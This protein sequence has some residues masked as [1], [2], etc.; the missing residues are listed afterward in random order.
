MR[1]AEGRRPPLLLLAL[2]V[3]SCVA[4]A[5]GAPRGGPP[6]AEREATGYQPTEHI[7]LPSG[8]FVVIHSEGPC[9]CAISHLVLSK[10][11]VEVALHSDESYAALLR[12]ADAGAGEAPPPLE[13]AEGGENYRRLAPCAGCPEGRRV[14]LVVRNIAHIDNVV[15]V[16]A[17]VH[18]S[19]GGSWVIPPL[20]GAAVRFPGPCPCRAAYSF[21]VADGGAVAAL[22]VPDELLERV[23]YPVSSPLE[24]AEG[25]PY[26]SSHSLPDPSGQANGSVPF[27]RVG[28]DADGGRAALVLFN[29]TER[30]INASLSL[31]VAAV[32]DQ[33]RV[34]SVSHTPTE[35]GS[36]LVVGSG[37]GPEGR[38]GVDEDE[39]SLR[40]TVGGAR[41]RR[42]LV[43]FPDYWLECWLPPGAGAGLPLTVSLGALTSAPAPFT[44]S[45]PTVES[46]DPIPAGGGPV[47]VRGANLGPAGTP[48]RLYVGPAECAAARVAEPH[49]A[50]ACEAPP[51]AGA[52][53]PVYVNVSGLLTRTGHAPSASYFPPPAPP[54][55]PPPGEPAPWRIVLAGPGEEGGEGSG[56]GSDGWRTL[57]VD[58]ASFPAAV[59]A[60]ADPSAPSFPR[61]GLALPA[62]G[63]LRSRGARRALPSLR[64]LCAPAARP[65]LRRRRRRPRRPL[66][67]RLSAPASFDPAA[68][69]PLELRYARRP[70]LRVP[71][72]LLGPAPALCLLRASSPY[73]PEDGPPLALTPEPLSPFPAPSAVLRPLL[74]A[75]FP[76]PP[77][78]PS[79]P[80]PPP[81][82]PS[83]PSSSAAP[84]GRR[85]PTPASASTRAPPPP[86]PRP[87]PPLAALLS[88]AASARALGRRRRPAFRLWLRDAAALGYGPPPPGRPAPARALQPGRH[89]AHLRAP[90]LARVQAPG[91][92]PALLPHVPHLL[93]PAGP[94]SFPPL[95]RPPVPSSGAPPDAPP[96]RDR[97]PD[98]T[99]PE[100]PTGRAHPEAPP[101]AA[102]MA[103]AP[104]PAVPPPYLSFV[105]ASRNDDYGGGLADRLQLVVRTLLIFAARWRLS[106]EIVFVEWNPPPD[107]PALPHALV[108]P[109]GGAPGG[110]PPVP[111]RHILV[112]PETHRRIPNSERIPMFDR[113]A[114][115]VGVRR[116]RGEFILFMNQDVLFC[117]GL[118]AILA[119]RLLRPGAFY[120]ARRYDVQAR[121]PPFAPYGRALASLAA[122][123][124]AGLV[125]PSRLAAASYGEDAAAAAAGRRAPDLAGTP[126]ARLTDSL[127]DNPG[128][129]HIMHRTHWHRARANPESPTYRHVD[130]WFTALCIAHNLSYVP[131]RA[132]YGI[133]HIYHERPLG[134][135]PELEDE[136]WDHFLA[137]ARPA[138][139][140]LFGGSRSNFASPSPP[141]KLLQP[142]PLALTP[143]RRAA[144][145]ERREPRTLNGAGWGLAGDAAVTEAALFTDP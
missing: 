69:D 117:D 141:P 14:H 79:R 50:A 13:R 68:H 106:A 29:P 83:A 138:R 87:S 89:S 93:A 30:P 129:L 137:M 24:L 145:A 60:S 76:P 100:F 54:P 110:A 136:T 16:G 67:Q 113:I 10:T 57:L 114:L 41:C 80:T 85:P 134:Q 75:L 140:K 51:G 90:L 26:F 47:T 45:P 133:F 86:P 42:P 65:A 78:P 121:V 96:R 33:P 125:I 12:G 143:S 49:R 104:D 59:A 122:H 1:S 63:P 71:P 3:A 127:L 9:P 132:P 120:Q 88:R 144:Q 92:R 111:V 74:W 118:G 39:A 102:P 70:P 119:R 142:P 52:A 116:A 84:F 23:A 35:G 44:F 72:L 38:E 36:L 5:Q 2:A 124:A 56:S 11:Y 25:L 20:S 53:L 95:A 98:T 135:R 46:V 91:P 128:D 108:Y 40:V 4:A 139:R 131:L 123:G 64:A 73:P 18:S 19:V 8:S 58:P 107:R 103:S 77:P 66:P 112:P 126:L 22:L 61:P 94:L 130:S 27:R 99:S 6:V 37:F 105:L 17:R 62:P 81:R 109:W 97:G 34:A 55:P 21:S 32:T 82:T 15:T 115:N 28:A 7:I 43:R 101:L 31:L 48:L